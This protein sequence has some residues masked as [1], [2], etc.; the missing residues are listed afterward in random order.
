MANFCG[1]DKVILKSGGSEAFEVAVKIAKRWG[2][3]EKGIKSDCA[4]VISAVNCFH[5]R[6]PYAIATSS[7]PEYK[8]DFGPFPPGIRQVVFNDPDALERVINENTACFVVEAIQGEGGIHVA[9]DG[10]LRECLRICRKNNVL[11]IVDE[12]QT[13]L[14]R[15]GYKFAYQHDDIEPDMIIMA[16]TLGGG[17]MPVS[18]VAANDNIMNLIHPGDEGSTFGSHPLSCV[19]ALEVL[20]TLEEEN[21]IKNARKIGNYFKSKIMGLNSPLIQEVRGRGLMVGVELV[22]G[23]K[24]PKFFCERLLQEGI[25]CEKA[26]KNVVRFSPPLII[27]EGD[28]DWAVRRINRVFGNLEKGN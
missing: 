20:L 3:Q 25:I 1:K 4:E 26:G 14:G 12:I 9:D 7:N 13:G 27:N 16:K 11:L 23:A 5:G 21:L 28:V 2:Y 8:K 22:S 10:Y 6:L 15:T 18:A 24:E 17:L 19:V